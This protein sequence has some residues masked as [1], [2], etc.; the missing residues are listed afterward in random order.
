MNSHKHA[1][2]TP[3][4]RALLVYRV[5]H[6]D[7]KVRDASS[8]AGVSERTGYKWLARFK[9]EGHA[10]LSDRSSRPWRSPSACDP[11]QLHRFEQRRRERQADGQTMQQCSHFSDSSCFW[12]DRMGAA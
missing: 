3:R 4:G 5:L 6:E 8:A 9:A 1:A 2:L 12:G 10:G 7:C 11:E